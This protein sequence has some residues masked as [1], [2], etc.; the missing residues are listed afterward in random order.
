MGS[1]GLVVMDEN[2]C[3]VDVARYFLDFARKESCGKC[4][5]CRLG[6]K[7]MLDI[8]EDICAGKGSLED[9]DLLESLSTGI[10]K[11]SLCGLGQT[12][13]NP[14]ITTLKYFRHEYEEHIHDKKCTS[15]VC[16]ELI[17]YDIL[18]DKCTGC[19]ICFKACP[20]K[21]ISGHPKE[22]HLIDQ[23]LCI[24]CG[25]CMEK[26]PEKFDAIGRYPG[27]KIKEEHLYE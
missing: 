16:K 2:T 9:I 17:F 10:I 23:D 12:A 8:L 13:P 6:T 1:G 26:C 4:T 18:P 5:P 20:V 14:V 15:L 21:A 27:K 25:M 22:P 11:G 24:K 7:Q 3:M 19:H